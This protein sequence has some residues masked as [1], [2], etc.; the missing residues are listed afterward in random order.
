MQKRNIGGSI[1]IIFDKSH[2]GR[3]PI[4]IPFEVDEPIGPFVTAPLV[5][6]GHTTI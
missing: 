2:F 5:P 6:G 1:G 4:F 3:N